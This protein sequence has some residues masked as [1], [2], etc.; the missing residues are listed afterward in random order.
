MSN[1][2]VMGVKII[3]ARLHL[4]SVPVSFHRS[5]ASFT[6]FVRKR[7]VA[8]TTYRACGEQIQVSRSSS[9]GKAHIETKCVC[10][11]PAILV[12]NLQR[13]IHNIEISSQKAKERRGFAKRKKAVCKFNILPRHLMAEPMCSVAAG[14]FVANTPVIR[15]FVSFLNFFFLVLLSY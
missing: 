12:L 15:N 1:T 8:P 7:T 3:L 11:Q 2:P 9:H 10:C 5:L 6:A 13:R 4:S 14:T